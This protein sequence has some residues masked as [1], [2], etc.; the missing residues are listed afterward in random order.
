MSGLLL[1][2]LARNLLA[3]GLKSFPGESSPPGPIEQLETVPHTSEV[4]A[5]SICVCITLFLLDWSSFLWT[6]NV[7]LMRE[8]LF[9]NWK[10]CFDQNLYYILVYGVLG[11]I[12]QKNQNHIWWPHRKNL[13]WKIIYKVLEKQLKQPGERWVNPEIRRCRKLLRLLGQEGQGEQVGSRLGLRH[14]SWDSGGTPWLVLDHWWKG[15][16]G[17]SHREVGSL[18]EMS[19]EA[20]RGRSILFSPFLSPPILC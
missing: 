18:P 10:S 1:D 2:G 12:Q 17:R 5:R 7:A 14:G 8:R 16:S 11:R 15:V 9:P 3:Q 13:T 6:C 20:E 19:P 4:E